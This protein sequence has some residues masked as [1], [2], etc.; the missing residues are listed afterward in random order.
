MN[1]ELRYPSDMPRFKAIARWVKEDMTNI[2]KTL[3]IRA[4]LGIA[5]M[6]IACAIELYKFGYVL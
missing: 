2:D 1:K 6:A 5:L 4:Y 3:L